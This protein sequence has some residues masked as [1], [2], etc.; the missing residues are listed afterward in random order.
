[1]SN[2]LYVLWAVLLGV[3]SFFTGEVV[4]YVMLGFILL[5]LN[6]I[7]KVMKEISRKMERKD[8]S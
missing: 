3:V 7:H 5:A 2:I 8:G 1:M 6:N 4:T